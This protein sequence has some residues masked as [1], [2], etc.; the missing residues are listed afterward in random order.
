MDG[1]GRSSV[2]RSVRPAKEEN[3]GQQGT[4]EQ[5]RTDLP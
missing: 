5:C 2:E 4:A 3:A 1:V